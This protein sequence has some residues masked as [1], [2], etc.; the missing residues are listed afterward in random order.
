MRRH[1]RNAC[2]DHGI[3]WANGEA[4]ER[5]ATDTRAGGTVRYVQCW[6]SF[7]RDERDAQSGDRGIGGVRGVADGGGAVVSGGDGVAGSRFD[8]A[9]GAS[10]RSRLAA[11]YLAVV[12]AGAAG[13][14]PEVSPGARTDETLCAAS[15]Y[16]RR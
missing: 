7:W 16:G 2:L 1:R 9:A 3:T 6:H 13:G 14:V 10:S 12:V 15:A 5:P 11:S 8:R 4:G